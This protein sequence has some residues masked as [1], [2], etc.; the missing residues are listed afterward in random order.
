MIISVRGPVPCWCLQCLPVALAMDQ[1]I[2]GYQSLSAINLRLP[3]LR[4][5]FFKVYFWDFLIDLCIYLKA[6][7]IN[8]T[9]RC[10]TF[11][12]KTIL[13]IVQT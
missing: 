10:P 13:T 6:K 7:L 4:H 8:E 11:F 2:L 5:V 1:L 12:L 9:E 3:A